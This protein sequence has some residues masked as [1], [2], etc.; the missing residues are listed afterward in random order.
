MLPRSC[1]KLTMWRPP[2]RGGCPRRRF[3]NR[4]QRKWGGIR[5]TTQEKK[6]KE[7]GRPMCTAVPAPPPSVFCRRKQFPHPATV[8]QLGTCVVWEGVGKWRNM[9]CSRPVGLATKLPAVFEKTQHSGGG[10]ACRWDGSSGGQNK[11]DGGPR[12][13]T[14]CLL[15]VAPAR[16]HGVEI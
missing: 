5:R 13:G 8:S 16:V 3:G 6:S 9:P 14:R 1:C 4:S 10:G 2:R 7:E 12:A 15:D 11:E